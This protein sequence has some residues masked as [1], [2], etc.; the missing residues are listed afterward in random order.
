M[1]IAFSAHAFFLFFVLSASCFATEIQE[2][3]MQR[4]EA[5]DFQRLSEFFTGK[6]YSDNR[7]ILRT[8]NDE[9]DGVYVDIALDCDASELPSGS[10]AILDVVFENNRNSQSFTFPITETPMNTSRIMFGITGKEWK[11]QP[12]V[13]AWKLEIHDSSGNLLCDY[14]SFLWEMPQ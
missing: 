4:H 9:R 1:R 13:I 11:E 12:K 5:K 10:V 8:T 3:H 14:K 7:L 2:A 6:E